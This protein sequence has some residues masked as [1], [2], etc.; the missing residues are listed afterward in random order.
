GPAARGQ[1]PAKQG[2]RVFTGPWCLAPGTYFLSSTSTNS[3][4]TTSSFFFSEVAPGPAPSCGGA[5]VGGVDEFL[6]IASASLW[7]ACVRL[8]TALLMSSTDPACMVLRVES[9]ASSTCFASASPILS[10][11]SFSIFSTWYT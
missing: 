7:L 2:P 4:S 8:S 6:Y 10:R 9:S 11:W 5:P 1:T 3:A